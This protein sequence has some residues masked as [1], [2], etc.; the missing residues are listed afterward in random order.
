MSL[1]V[2]LAWALR[3][4]ARGRH[5]QHRAVGRAH[6]GGRGE[7]REGR[8]ALRRPERHDGR[9]NQGDQARADRRGAGQQVHAHELLRQ[10]CEWAVWAIPVSLHL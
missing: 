8:R 2:H 10:V 1:R 7:L 4:P 6:C 3:R 9:P 5:D